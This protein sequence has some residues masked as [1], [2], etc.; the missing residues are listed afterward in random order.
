MRFRYSLRVKLT[1]L[2]LIVMILPVLVIIFALPTV[3]RNLFTSESETLTQ[4][5]L[6]SLTRNIETYLDDLDRLTIAPY[7]YSDVMRALQLKA[8]GS[9]PSA[10]GH[11]KYL[12]EQAL[13]TAL[14]EFLLN[15]RQDIAATIM[16]P[17]DGSVYISSR[18]TSGSVSGYPFTQ[19]SWYRQAIQADGK[20]AFVSTHPQDY[21]PLSPQKQVFS[22]ARLIKDPDSRRPLAVMMADA[23][24]RVLSKITSDLQLNVNSIVA[25]LDSNH[26][27]IFSSAPLSDTLLKQIADQSPA[28]E[29]DGD[30]FVSVSRTIESSQWAVV[31]L[32]S[33]SEINAKLRWIY[34]IGILFAL[35]GLVLAF[36]VFF[37]LSRWIVDPFQDMIQVMKRVQRGDLASRFKPQGRDEIAEL[38]DALNTMIG[39]LSDLIDREYKAVLNQRNAEFMAL[40]AQI[41]PHFLY[42]TLNSFIALNRLREQ[43]ALERAIYA[44]SNMLRYTLR[45]DEWATIKEEFQFLQRYCELQRLRFEDRLNVEIQ[46]ETEASAIK[47]Q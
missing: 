6:T 43:A 9:Y 46:F 22:V 38:G 40:Q 19:Q 39:R 37:T 16:L 47:I 21:L 10:D 26:Q 20:V 18:D 31:I 36:V 1:I 15:P 5:L 34:V 44:L 7:L 12:S 8:S 3:Y 32:Q 17:M 24:T 45:R 35:G 28:L 11:T 2:F 23:D 41:Q 13:N 42:N 25:V 27:L 30:S 4:A 29:G 14:P 33:S